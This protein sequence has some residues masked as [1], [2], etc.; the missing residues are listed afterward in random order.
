MAEITRIIDYF[1]K[2]TVLPLLCL[3]FV[4]PLQ[5]NAKENTYLISYVRHPEVISRYLP[6]IKQVYED[7][8]VNCEFRPDSTTRGITGVDQGLFDADVARH[9]SVGWQFKHVLLVH[10]ALTEATLFLVC[11]Q[12]LSCDK[13]QLETEDTAVLATRMQIRHL[14]NAF[15]S[16]LKARFIQWEDH[17]NMLELVRQG[18][19]N[20]A[21]MELQKDAIPADIKS[22]FGLVPLYDFNVYHVINEKHK[23]LLPQLS[24]ALK[25][26]LEQSQKP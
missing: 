8:G 4:I 10:P 7:I 12:G 21:L 14:H 15:T 18:H 2:R 22:T 1:M 26:R 23:A 16:P 11:R 19:A 3:S 9:A 13:K 5:G 17:A 6:L 20:Y 25:A 24:R